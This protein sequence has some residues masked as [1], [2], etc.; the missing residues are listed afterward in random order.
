MLD[1]PVYGPIVGRVL[2][3]ASQNSAPRPIHAPVDLASHIRAGARTNLDFFPEDVAT[4]VAT[5]LA[6][7]TMLEECFGIPARDARLSF[8][9]SI[10]ELSALVWSGVFTLEQLLPVPLGLASGLRRAGRRPDD[11]RP[12]HP[13]P[14]PADGRGRAALPGISSEGTG[15]IGPSAFLSPNTALILGQGDTIDRLDPAKGSLL[16]HKSQR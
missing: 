6:Q 16:S 1:H 8:G 10:G 14:G 9:Y 2:A 7:M 3:E 4:I 15:L 5:E 13:R 12:L 11:G